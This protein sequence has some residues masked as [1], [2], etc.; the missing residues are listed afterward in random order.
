MPCT[1]HPVLSCCS[2]F[3]GIY[4][5]P[6]DPNVKKPITSI[7]NTPSVSVYHI[8]NLTS[9]CLTYTNSTKVTNSDLNVTS[10]FT[11]QEKEQ[12]CRADERYIISI[13][14]SHVGCITQDT[15][16]R[17]RSQ[18]HHRRSITTSNRN[19]RT[20][21]IHQP[22]QSRTLALHKSIF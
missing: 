16:T 15:I 22:Q 7:T 1:D 14:Q 19:H 5:G 17:Y 13:N 21:H 10:R 3:P 9:R 6:T 8:H 2:G 11:S 18:Q 4:I 20:Q 12:Y